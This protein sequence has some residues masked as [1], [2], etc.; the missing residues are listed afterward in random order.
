VHIGFAISRTRFPE[1]LCE[2]EINRG[3]VLWVTRT[4]ERSWKSF[5]SS[6]RV[7]EEGPGESGL[8]VEGRLRQVVSE[9]D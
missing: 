5:D 4:P 6:G 7:K 1:T 2:G 8:S 3:V 9:R